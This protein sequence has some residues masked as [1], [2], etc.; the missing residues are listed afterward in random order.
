MSE[1]NTTNESTP[2]RGLNFNALK[3]HVLEH[4]IFVA[5]LCTRILTIIFALGYIFP[6]FGTS[7]NAY[8]KALL[9]NAAT[10]ALRLH[11]R[12]GRVQFTSAFFRELVREDSCHYLF[13]SLIYLYV[14][15]IT[16]VLLPIT[17]FA[18]LHAASY[19]LTLLDALG[20]NAW[21]GARLLISI[22]EFQSRNILRLAAFTE[23]M[24]M[25]MTIILILMGKAGLLTPFIYYHFLV[26]RYSS[27]RN[28]YTRNMFHELRVLLEAAAA[29]PSMPGILK[30]LLLRV[31]SI[32]CKLAPP[33]VAQQ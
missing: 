16:L 30:Q 1:T 5:L 6:I 33:Q 19:S 22:V 29:K 17:L 26:Q 32:S 10:S 15:P 9:S 23:I 21:W 25:P 11:Q 31:V 3:T 13:Y 7:Y 8:Y 24:L 12:L 4:K 14:A 28:P 27:R 20:Q 18:I 2:Q